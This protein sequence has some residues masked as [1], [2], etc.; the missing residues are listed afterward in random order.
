MYVT[1][2]G[3]D[4][5]VRYS[6]QGDPVVCLHGFPLSGELWS[7][8]AQAQSDRNTLVIPDLRGMGQS[9]GS[10]KC[11][12]GD[13]ADD[14]ALVLEA[15][16]EE[17]PVVL[18]ALSMGGYVAFEFLRRYPERVRALVLV[19]TQAT[20]DAEEARRGREEMARRVLAEGSQVVADAMVPKLFAPSA[21]HELKQ[22][23]QRI[24]ADSDPEGLAAA[25]LAMRDREDSFATLA[26][27]QKPALVVVG[28]HDAI[29]PP[30]A[31]E[32]MHRELADSQLSIVPGA[33][34]MTP[35][36]RPGEFNAM[37]ARFLV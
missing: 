28:E 13:Y 19:D 23:W 11:N 24:M 37:V 20:A 33:G 8:L 5:F 18:V 2:R 3:A 27:F 9:K 32:A 34:H 15:L 16:D 30:A 12:M 17:R 29:T 22:H 31:A 14:V 25:L 21:S 36:E 35:V 4:L 10:P 26:E 7:G 6:G 1:A